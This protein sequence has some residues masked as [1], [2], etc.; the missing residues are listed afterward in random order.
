[1]GKIAHRAKVVA[2]WE[3]RHPESRVNC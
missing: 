3:G 2:A 1:V